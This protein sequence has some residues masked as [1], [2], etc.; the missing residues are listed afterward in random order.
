MTIRF[1][2]PL[3]DDQ[4]DIKFITKRREP[5]SAES[6]KCDVVQTIHL[7][8][9]IPGGI[10]VEVLDSVLR[11]PQTAG[12]VLDSGPS[13]KWTLDATSLLGLKSEGIK[14]IDDQALIQSGVP[15]ISGIQVEV[16]ITCWLRLTGPRLSPRIGCED[17][18]YVLD[19]E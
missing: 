6:P 3:I 14:S 4:P 7:H 13:K 16:L 10:D 9:K 18:R 2:R 17:R 12:Y 8:H 5:T 1:G 19:V 15:H 11:L